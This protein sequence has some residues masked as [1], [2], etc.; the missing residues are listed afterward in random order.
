MARDIESGVDQW[1]SQ[2]YRLIPKG[3]KVGRTEKGKERKKVLNK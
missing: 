1:E 2:F 3:L